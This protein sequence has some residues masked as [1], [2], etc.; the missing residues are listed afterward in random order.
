MVLTAMNG[1]PWWF[2]DGFGGALEGTTLAAADPDGAI[3]QAIAI[4][5]VI[6]CVVHATCTVAGPGLV[7]H[8]FGDRLII[9]EPHGGNSQ[10]IQ[11]VAA[12][13]RH[14]G[15]EIQVSAQIQHDIWYKLWG[16]MTIN[17]VSAITGATS[18]RILDDELVKTFCDAVMGEASQIGSRIGCV[19]TQSPADRNAV[20]RKLGAFKTSMLQDVEA[21]RPVEIDALL[22]VAREIGQKVGMPTPNLDA[23]LGISRLHARMHGLYPPA[24]LRRDSSTR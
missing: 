14:A 11:A 12:M 3:A 19:I 2:F 22:S 13:L 20:T 15:F 9:G 1:V 10:R 5:R 16:N 24:D 21:G 18:D 17:P 6:G 8:G 4:R 7:Q 23:L